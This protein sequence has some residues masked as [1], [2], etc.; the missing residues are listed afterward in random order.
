MRFKNNSGQEIELYAGLCKS[1]DDICNF[2][3]VDGDIPCC[4]YCGEPDD[5]LDPLYIEKDA[6][7]EWN[8][9][10]IDGG[11][12]IYHKYPTDERESIFQTVPAG[13]DAPT[14]D[15][16]YY[17]LISLKRLKGITE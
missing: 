1:C 12:D 3:S 13:E 15:A 5:D 8:Y 11:F 4:T 6:E 9:M 17:N 16:G 7:D 14:G 10:E 2:R